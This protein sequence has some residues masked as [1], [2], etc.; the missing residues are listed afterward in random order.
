MLGT[1]RAPVLDLVLLDEDNPRSLTFSLVDIAAH[2]K[3]LPN[4]RVSDVPR[5]A[6][7]LAETLVAEI[8]AVGPA[9]ITNERLIGIE[10]ELMRLS[11]EIS[12]TYF[13][14]REPATAEAGDR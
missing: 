14:L 11:N 10:N 13:T 3:T 12:H 4:A 8:R 7:A 1:A 5:P 9:N 2:L 6:L